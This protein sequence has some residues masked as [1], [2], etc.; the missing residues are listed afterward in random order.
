MESARRAREQERMSAH[1]AAAEL[2]RDMWQRAVPAAVDH[3]Y[4]QRK[5]VPA[6]GLR[7]LGSEILVPLATVDGAL[8]NLQRI[9]PDGRKLFLKGGRITGCFCLLSRDLPE[10]GELYLAEGWATAATISADTR[11]PVAAAMNA[12][13]LKPVA[14]AIRA[15]RPSLAIV[16]AADNDHQTYGNPGIRAARAAAR[17]VDG[18]VTW[19]SLCRQP[20]CTCTDFNDVQHCGRVTA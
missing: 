18:A 6:L 16:I 11:L 14:E 10:R 9:R 7:Q 1:L 4:I 15:A 12:G 17:A 5:R 3:P 2:S 19:P 20:D 8:V 13:N